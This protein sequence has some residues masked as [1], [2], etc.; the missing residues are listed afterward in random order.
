VAR[1]FDCRTPAAIISAALVLFSAVAGV[2]QDNTI[3]VPVRLVL[4]PTLVFSKEGNLV[5]G[6]QIGDFH[7]YDNGQ[8]Q[9]INL[10]VERPPL[11]V[12]VIVQ[13][14]R[15]IRQY[16]PFI[17]KVGSLLDSAILG[18]K[19][20]AALIS[21][22]DNVAVIKPFS[23]GDLSA[24]MESLTASGEGAHMIDAGL[25]GTQLL[26]A[27]A[28]FRSRV[29]LFIGQAFDS[30]STAN[31]AALKNDVQRDSTTVYTLRLPQFGNA[32]LSGTVS[33]DSAPGGFKA[34]V[35]L[36]K[37]FPALRHHQQISSGNDPFSELSTETGGVQMRVRKQNQL[38]DALIKMGDDLRSTYLLTYSPTEFT[39]GH[40]KITVE[41]DVPGTHTHSRSG[42]KVSTN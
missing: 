27:H 33:L 13:C 4:V 3:R 42:Y 32:L 28:K 16:L 23:S 29:L 8:A 22:N 35:E 36:T 17:E 34:G 31:L 21:Y 5:N 1:T 40:H 38:E 9:K 24:S 41:T 20:E 25:R 6:L 18:E 11:A 30:G 37:L 12:V 2:A 19:G 7:L 26:K 14:N 15:D 10:D 39:P